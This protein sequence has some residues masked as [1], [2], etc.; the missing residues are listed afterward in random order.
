MYLQ[1]A[2]DAGKALA[3]GARLF[4]IGAGDLYRHEDRAAPGAGWLRELGREL[5]KGTA[6]VSWGG[7]RSLADH[8]DRAKA[9]ATSIIVGRG[10]S[11]VREGWRRREGGG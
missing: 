1:D 9:G 4:A 5:P 7:V 8:D 6:R 10:Y 3:A 2:E 11:S